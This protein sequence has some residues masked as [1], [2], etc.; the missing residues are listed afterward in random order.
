MKKHLY[1]AL[2]IMLTVFITM[3]M[4]PVTAF[5]LNGTLTINT[6]GP[7]G[8]TPV[9]NVGVDVIRNHGGG[10]DVIWS[11]V[12]NESGTLSVPASAFASIIAGDD[13]VV[14]VNSANHN[15][16]T[17]T[18]AR[19][20]SN[21]NAC[22]IVT[23]G[24]GHQQIE[25]KSENFSATFNMRNITP[26]NAVVNYKITWIDGDGSTLA[27]DTVASGETPSYNGEKSPSKEADAQYTYTFKGW[28]PAIAPATQDQVY[29]AQ[30]DF[31]VNEYLITW[32]DGNGNTIYEEMVPYGQNPYYSRNDAP[33]KQG[34]AQY[35]YEFAGRWEPALAPVDGEATYTAQF[36]TITNK[37]LITWVDGNGDTLLEEEVE[38]GTVPSYTGNTTPEKDPD[39][40][41]YT[42]NGSWDPVPAAVTG[43]ATYTAQFDSTLIDN[44]QGNRSITVKTL[45]KEGNAIAN[46]DVA[47][48]LNPMNGG[49]HTV[50]YRGTTDENGMLT[51][52]HNALAD[53]KAGQRLYADVDS[54]VHDWDTV[55]GQARAVEDVIN[56]EIITDTQ[57][58]NN[59]YVQIN[60]NIKD[61]HGFGATFIL[62]GV[63]NIEY[64]ITFNPG[65]GTVE[66]QSKTVICGQAYGE[67]P[68]P[69]REGYDFLG[70]RIP[71]END[72][73][74]PNTIVTLPD[75]HELIA[76]WQVKTFTVIWYDENGDVLETDRAVPYGT[77]PEFNGAE[78]TKEST[79]QYDYQFDSW[80]PE[81]TAVT[82]NQE[83]T[84]VY[85]SEVREYTVIWAYE[86]GTEIETDEYVPYGTMPEFNGNEPELEDHVFTGWAP[87]VSEVTGDITYTAQFKFTTRTVNIKTVDINGNPVAGVS[88]QLYINLN[89]NNGIEDHQPMG[90]VFT[91]DASGE[92][93]VTTKDASAPANLRDAAYGV[94]LYASVTGEDFDWANTKPVRIAQAG[95]NTAV[96]T[97]SDNNGYLWLTA[98]ESEDGFTGTITLVV[99]EPGDMTTTYNRKIT[100]TV[101]DA[102]GNPIEGV[103]VVLMVNTNETGTIED[104]SQLSGAVVTDAN[105]QAVFGDDVLGGVAKGNYIYANVSDSRF[106]FAWDLG[107]VRTSSATKGATAF[108]SSEQGYL[109]ITAN[110][111][112]AIEGAFVIFA[113]ATSV[114]VTWVNYDG[115]ELEVD[116]EVPCGTM[117]EYNGETPERESTAQYHY[118]FIGWEPEVTEATE[119]IIYTAVFEEE[120]RSYTITYTD[121]MR[122]IELFADQE[123]VAP[124]GTT[125][126]EFEGSLDIPG[127]TFH[128]WSPTFED[129]VTGD[130][131]YT[132]IFR[133]IFYNKPD[134]SVDPEVNITGL[135]TKEHFA[136]IIGYGDEFRPMNDVT[137]A[138]AAT[139]FFR[140]MTDK[141]RSENWDNAA[142]YS[143]VPTNAWYSVAVATLENAGIIVD[144]DRGG[145]FRPND[146]I[147]RAELAVMAAQFCTLTGDIP[148]SSFGDVSEKHWAAAEIALIEYTG[149]IKGYRGDFRPDDNVTRAECVT[150]I[151]RMINR[152]C[153]EENMIEG[154]AR[155]TDVNVDDWF[156][157]EITEAAT[158]HTYERTD[159]RIPGENIVAEE[160][161]T[162]E[163]APNWVEIEKSWIPKNI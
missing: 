12:T 88:V 60:A 7:D 35:S 62:Y 124:Y 51:V 82:T 126:P 144:T 117:P 145:A 23:V 140:L 110:K 11:G 26:K 84:A 105:G 143:D 161:I 149:W 141:F 38:Y 97:D 148:A 67:L 119:D 83:Y 27:E 61:E 20:V 15:W 101:Q 132:A 46:V 91:T 153:E 94:T 163:E 24:G 29:T 146:P 121:G 75:T 59:Q 98:E 95:V 42:F 64:D 21:N 86:D 139:M 96:V 14:S 130:V 133:D 37:Y 71:G 1:R 80:T 109:N 40:Y 30:F 54:I 81:F 152:G 53:V 33:T 142:S 18:T 16:D 65:E 99:S 108:T 49:A 52:P 63:S 87:E 147:T 131:V 25:V 36:N 103:S 104:H 116:E 79:A 106:D 28:D 13:I 112:E 56:A 66:P 154:A 92:F 2:S 150:M 74:T 17:T 76:E 48:R 127:Y 157:E 159:E 34:D 50:I 135:N 19:T 57:D 120:L 151:N 136:Y 69:E 41:S 77:M 6:F 85:S 114:K 47:L 45:D 39:D 93:A 160:W 134:V 44:S 68:T 22:S 138:E 162:I 100:V 118:N 55:S 158:S 129:T 73:V 111:G 32:V 155:F 4:M 107:T 125:T 115:T 128:G 89:Q 122:G 137:R 102:E 10:N 123:H 58:N 113:E 70:W 31:T 8:T 3:A 156:Y 90:N 78:P 72:Y 9:G 43:T 5:A